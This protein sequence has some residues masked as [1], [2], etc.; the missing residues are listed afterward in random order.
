MKYPYIKPTRYVHD[1]G[2][3]CF[4]TGYCE[5]GG[6]SEAINIEPLG[7]CTDHLWLADFSRILG[8]RQRIRD[9]NMD[10]TRNGYIRIFSN[11]EG[12]KLRWEGSQSYALSTMRLELVP[13]TE[14][15]QRQRR[16]EPEQ[17]EKNDFEF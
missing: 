16:G 9:I 1:S 12:M 8:G 7:R 11:T 14:S 5:I 17:P 4:E 3:R 15:E 10:L 2:Y 13:M 6:R